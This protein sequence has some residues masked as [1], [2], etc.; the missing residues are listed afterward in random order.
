MNVSPEELL[1]VA[2]SFA[3]FGYHYGTAAVPLETCKQCAQ[4]QF[5]AVVGQKMSSEGEE[6]TQ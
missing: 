5:S 2:L 6:T 3:E 4:E 1:E